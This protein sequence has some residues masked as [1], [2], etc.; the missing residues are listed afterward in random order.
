[1]SVPHARGFLLMRRGGGVWGIANATVD[2]LTWR[3]G[4]YRVEAGGGVLVA[5]EILGVVEDLRVQPAGPWLRRF[6]PVEMAGLAVHGEQPVV[7]VDPG[8][9]PDALRSVVAEQTDRGDGLD[10]ASD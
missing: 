9:P 1:M 8:S 2:G 4:G 7:V 6:L 10:E 3:D 5:D